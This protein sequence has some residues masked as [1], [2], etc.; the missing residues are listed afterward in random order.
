MTNIAPVRYAF[1]SLAL[2]LA[3]GVTAS[4]SESNFA[5]GSKSGDGFGLGSGGSSGKGNDGDETDCDPAR[6]P[7]CELGNPDGTLPGGTGTGGPDSDG[8]GVPDAL[9]PGDSNADGIPDAQQPLVNGS[10]DANGDGIPDVPGLE[11][12]DGTQTNDLFEDGTIT[13]TDH[14]DDHTLT[15]T[16]LKA[17]MP[18][19]SPFINKVD[20]DVNAITLT[21]ACRTNKP[22]CF[23][24]KV[25][26]KV[27]QVLGRDSCIM[28]ESQDMNS[29]TIN[30]DADGA[31]LIGSCV[32]PGS[33][34][35]FVIT[36]PHGI[37]PQ[38]CA[39]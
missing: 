35:R 20:D 3:A 9:E 10:G 4:C 21:K 16:R 33:D 34:E 18:D 23:Q 38:G 36:C 6:D 25:N 30:V 37:E 8:D 7:N 26:G 17:A 28:V 27:E 39:G 32:G 11:E 5:G 12:G 31:A 22:T 19:G 1:F 29:I 13:Y 15:I 24:I 2:L 14:D